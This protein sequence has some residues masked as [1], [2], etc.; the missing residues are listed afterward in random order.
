MTVSLREIR[1]TL[2]GEVLDGAC[3]V[4]RQKLI[5]TIAGGT[6]TGTGTGR[7][8]VK[9]LEAGGGSGRFRQVV[10]AILMI[11][12]N[13]SQTREYKDIYEDMIQKVHTI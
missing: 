10:T 8:L 13:L 11:G 4:L 5:T 6:G 7:E 2:H 12:S 3:G 1:N 9:K